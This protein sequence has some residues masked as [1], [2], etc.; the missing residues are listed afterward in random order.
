[1]RRT[2]LA[3][4]A[5]LLLPVGLQAQLPADP[6]VM[7]GFLAWD[8]GDYHVALELYSYNFV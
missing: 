5:A 8:R 6:T 4:F 2:L 3:G 1:M 7:E